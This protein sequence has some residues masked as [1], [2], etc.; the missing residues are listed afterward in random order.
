MKRL[1]KKISD[2]FKGTLYYLN[3]QVDD[4]YFYKYID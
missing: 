4:F 3:R 1:I 2:E